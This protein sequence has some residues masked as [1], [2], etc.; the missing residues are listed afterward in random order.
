[1]NLLHLRQNQMINFALVQAVTYRPSAK[2][3]DGTQS[4]ELQI[5]FQGG[6]TTLYGPEAKRAWS[7]LRTTVY[8]GTNNTQKGQPK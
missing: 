4:P 1:M 2:Q 8:R 3:D 7:L 6:S 5:S